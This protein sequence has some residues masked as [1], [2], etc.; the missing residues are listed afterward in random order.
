[1]RSL[2]GLVMGSRPL[3]G[4]LVGHC[5]GVHRELSRFRFGF[6]SQGYIC[7]ARAQETDNR[8]AARMCC[9]LL[10]AYRLHT[11]VLLMAQS[12]AGIAQ[13][14]QIARGRQVGWQ[15]RKGLVQQCIWQRAAAAV[16]DDRML[17]RLPLD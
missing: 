2:G 11:T 6:S 14:E 15:A 17:H 3:S 5:W 13:V 4:K 12:V 16:V 10:S 1:M 7:I 8:W 9:P